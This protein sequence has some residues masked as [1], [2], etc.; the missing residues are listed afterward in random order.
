MM[1]YGTVYMRFERQGTSLHVHKQLI[2]DICNRDGFPIFV[3]DRQPLIEHGNLVRCLLVVR[4][5]KKPLL[6]YSMDLLQL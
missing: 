6:C 5:G 3:S 1:G 4:N 2:F